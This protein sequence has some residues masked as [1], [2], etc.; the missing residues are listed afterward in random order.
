MIVFSVLQPA[1][2]YF[3]LLWLSALW[4]MRLP[5]RLM[6]ASQCKGLLP[7]HW[8]VELGL[9]PLVSRAVLKKTLSSLSAD[10]Q[11]G[12]SPCWLFGLRQPSTGAYRL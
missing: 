12:V 1:G 8:W 6:Q 4:W 7:A 3:F 10:G 2:F 5:K 9:V 11:V